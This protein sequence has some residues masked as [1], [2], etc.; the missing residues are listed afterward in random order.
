MYF[1]FVHH[2]VECYTV[3]DG[4]FIRYLRA[5][6]S[7]HIFYLFVSSYFRSVVGEQ[8]SFIVNFGGFSGICLIDGTF[9]LFVSFLGNVCQKYPKPISKA[10]TASDWLWVNNVIGVFF[11]ANAAYVKLK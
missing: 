10:K 5:V 1:P 7:L 4:V 2:F 3:C 9:R 8:F 6:V 11:L